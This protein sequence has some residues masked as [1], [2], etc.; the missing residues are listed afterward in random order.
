MYSISGQLI[1]Q[2]FKEF[3]SHY[4]TH[5]RRISPTQPPLLV[6]RVKVTFQNE[7]GEGSGVARSFYT[8]LAEALLSGQTIPSLEA[9]QSGPVQHKSMQLS[10]IQ[11]LRGSRDARDRSRSS[12]SKSRARDSTRN[13]SYDARPF[14]FNNEGGNNEHLSHHQ[15][16]LG[17]RLYPRVQSLRPSLSG[18][19]TGMLL[20]LTPAQLL[21]LLASEDSLR[22]RV[23]EAVEIILSAEGTSGP[24]S[25]AGVSSS[26]TGQELDHPPPSHQESLSPLDVFNL[27]TN[28]SSSLPVTS[29]PALTASSIPSITSTP[30]ILATKAALRDTPERMDV[31]LGDENAPLFY[32]PGKRGFYS[33]RMS[34]P[35][36][37]RLNAFRNVGRLI[38]LCLLQNELCPLF[39]NRHVLK[40]G[41]QHNIDLFSHLFSQFILGRP[42]RF[43]DLAF[44]DPVIYESL[45]QLVVDAEK[46]G[47]EGGSALQ[48]LDLTFSIDL[49]VEEGGGSVELIANGNNCPSPD[50]S[51]TA[52][53]S[54]RDSEVNNIN[55]YQYVRKYAEYRMVTSQEKA[56]KKVHNTFYI[57]LLSL[58]IIL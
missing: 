21:L 20:E 7:P 57:C 2:A 45:R 23:E 12:H 29:S 36:D 1:V 53:L 18:K 38:G 35:S 39:L 30:S 26:G 8:A 31:D 40:V 27:A 34:R 55:I 15:Q 32:Q 16:Q 19:I 25:S 11:R 44:F 47:V 9:A 14:Y 41:S 24:P 22:Q 10:L 56:L 4:Q 54:G 50:L 43:H 46:P 42:I 13:L 5:S 37:T 52:V 6:N 28:T 48:A 58:T 3:N 49:C 33:P 17:E 51:L